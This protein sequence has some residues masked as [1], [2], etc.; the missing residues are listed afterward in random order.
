MEVSA[1]TTNEH[2]LW[3]NTDLLSDRKDSQPCSVFLKTIMQSIEVTDEGLV[4]HETA[5]EITADCFRLIFM[6]GAMP[7]RSY[8]QYSTVSFIDS[9]ARHSYSRVEFRRN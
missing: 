9:G 2:M 6:F 8:I 1:Q 4:S 3:P 5:R 7:D